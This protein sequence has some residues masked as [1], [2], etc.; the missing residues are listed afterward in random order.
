[1]T[2]SFDYHG[3]SDD[4]MDELIDELITHRYRLEDD[5]FYF[6]DVIREANQSWCQ[7]PIM[8]EVDE[9]FYDEFGYVDAKS[10]NYSSVINEKVLKQMEKEFNKGRYL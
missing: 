9:C 6:I 3:Y 4:E 8:F 7:Q 1:M 5:E 10:A 2:H